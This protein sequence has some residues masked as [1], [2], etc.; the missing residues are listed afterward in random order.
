MRASPPIPIA[1]T[2]RQRDASRLDAMPTYRLRIELPDRPGALAGV[3]RAL[4]DSDANIVSID[5]HE[6]DGDTAVDEIVVDVSLDW[7]PRNLA[8]GLAASGA[9]TLLSSRRVTTV[10]DP[11]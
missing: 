10:E 8:A 11:L 7:A 2:P 6:V 1:E 9:G 5:V 3:T 4:A